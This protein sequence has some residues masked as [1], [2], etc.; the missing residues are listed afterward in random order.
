MYYSVEAANPETLRRAFLRDLDWRIAILRHD[1][2]VNGAKI[3][4]ASVADKHLLLR[5]LIFLQEYWAKIT[6]ITPPKVRA[7]RKPKTP[8]PAHAR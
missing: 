2:M 8:E 3:A 4:G 6:I 5:E 7:K 1:I